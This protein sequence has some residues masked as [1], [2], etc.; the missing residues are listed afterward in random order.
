MEDPS[1]FD[2]VRPTYKAIYPF[3]IY[4]ASSKITRRYTLYAPSDGM[5]KK[6]KYALAD[7]LAV[8]KVHQES[9]MVR[10]LK[11]LAEHTLL[12]IL[13]S[14]Q[15]LAP[16][17]VRTGFYKHLKPGQPSNDKTRIMGRI[18]AAAPM[19]K[20]CLHSGIRESRGLIRRATTVS[21]GRS[22]VIIG[23]ATGIYTAQRGKSGERRSLFNVLIIYKLS[24]LT[25]S[26]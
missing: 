21:Y 10:V 12:L 14:S 1:I 9:N 20:R 7:A 25:R 6:W 8:R 22:F 2:R 24:Y 19:C 23:S 4:H 11:S 15:W 26:H 16:H 3:T 13:F 18:T 5:R 17:D